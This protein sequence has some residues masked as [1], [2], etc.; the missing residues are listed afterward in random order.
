[1]IFA[2]SVREDRHG[3]FI[4]QKPEK[5]AKSPVP[6]NFTKKTRKTVLLKIFFRKKRSYNPTF[7]QIIIIFKTYYYLFI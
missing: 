7:L 5:M 2:V 6:P 4:H 1:M 3:F